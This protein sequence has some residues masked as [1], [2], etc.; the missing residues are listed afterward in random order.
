VSECDPP[1]GHRLDPRYRPRTCCLQ[2]EACRHFPRRSRGSH[3]H[4]RPDR[5]HGGRPQP[6]TVE[7]IV[8]DN[9]R[10]TFTGSEAARDVLKGALVGAAVVGVAAA[11]ANSND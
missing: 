4:W 10:I 5:H 8:V 11:I 6:T 2:Q 1:P 7:A 3:H 9:G